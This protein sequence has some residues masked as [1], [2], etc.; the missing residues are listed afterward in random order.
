MSEESLQRIRLSRGVVGKTTYTAIA[1]FGVLGIVAARLPSDMLLALALI[2]CAIFLIYFVGLL[3]FANKNPAAALL[4]G[5]ELL[6]WQ[7]TELAAKGTGPIPL[8]PAITPPR[9]LPPVD[10]EGQ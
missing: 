1:F 6:H 7:Q 3:H 10:R 5:A 8:Q 9:E 4:E 2:A